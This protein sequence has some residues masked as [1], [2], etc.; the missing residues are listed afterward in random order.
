MNKITILLSYRKKIV[1]WMMAG[2]LIF[3]ASCVFS[4]EQG[5]LQ[6]NDKDQAK[7]PTQ[8]AGRVQVGTSLLDPNPQLR[9]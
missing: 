1:I 4:V 8:G 5:A 9:I 2:C 7:P 6:E 3:A